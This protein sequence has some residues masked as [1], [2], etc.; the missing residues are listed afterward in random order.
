M[1]AS[2]TGFVHV[3]DQRYGD[4]ETGSHFDRFSR[5]DFWPIQSADLYFMHAFFVACGG[6]NHRN[7]E[8][9]VR[10]VAAEAGRESSHCRTA[11][12]QSEVPDSLEA[13][14]RSLLGSG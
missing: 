11:K 12:S 5:I 1:D 13:G 10:P 9:G 7:V 3:C 6:T 14:P 8:V 2:C 4:L